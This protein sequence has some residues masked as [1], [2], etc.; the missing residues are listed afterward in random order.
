[1]YQFV[2]V[3]PSMRSTPPSPPSGPS[4]LALAGQVILAEHPLE[5]L[6]Q[7]KEEQVG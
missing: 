4:G 2:H 3:D 1:M 7:R 6:Q 5:L